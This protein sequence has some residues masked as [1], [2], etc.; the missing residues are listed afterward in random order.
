MAKDKLTKAYEAS[1]VRDKSSASFFGDNAQSRENRAFLAG[2]LFLGGTLSALGGGIFA[3]VHP[4][5]TQETVT[6]TVTDKDLRGDF[7]VMTAHTDKKTGQQVKEIFEN[8]REI[9]FLK[10][11]NEEI[12][13]SLEKGQ[14]YEARV[15]GYSNQT[16][17]WK[18]NIIS[19]KPAVKKP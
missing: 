1:L 13:D 4:Y 12:Q 3:V 16:M 14:S 6:F 8:E 7:N 17:G 11:N 15:Y 10:F 18:R 2:F 5:L 9:L 19:V